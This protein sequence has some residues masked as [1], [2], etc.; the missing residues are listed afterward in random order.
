M[1][2]SVAILG[3]GVAGLSAA[4]ELV[5]LGYRVNVYERRPAL[6]GKAQSQRRPATGAGGRNDL[7]GEHGFRF[8]PSFYRYLIL[9]MSE[10]PLDPSKPGGPKVADNLRACDEAGFGA[11][12]GRGLRKMLRREPKTLFE[13]TETLSLFFADLH[14][15]PTD[16][17]RFGKKILRY[18]T[19]C[20][21]RRDS[22]YEEMSWWRFVDGDSYDSKFQKYLRCV[23]RIMVAM[24]PRR[25]SART[26]GNIS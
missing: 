23:P 3:G 11:A 24:D 13:L 19:S 5:R 2:K 4:H 17:G 15:S 26:I 9:T 6:G 10:I 7:P 21:E 16:V 20:T 25:G 12:D 1:Q 22:E 18:L 14:M 8:Y